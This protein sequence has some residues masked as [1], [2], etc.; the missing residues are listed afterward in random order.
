MPNRKRQKFESIVSAG[1]ISKLPIA[2]RFLIRTPTD[3]VGEMYQN[4]RFSSSTR[5][6]TSSL[7]NYRDF[8]P[9]STIF[10]EQDNLK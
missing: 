1:D 7:N 3:C 8:A 4:V 6:Q 9:L 5:M 10:I 2:F